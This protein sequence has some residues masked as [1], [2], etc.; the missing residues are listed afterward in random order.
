VKGVNANT[1]SDNNDMG[2]DGN[3]NGF[4]EDAFGYSLHYNKNDYKAI[5][6]SSSEQFLSAVASGAQAADIYN[7][8][9]SKMA[10]ALHNMPNLTKTYQYD[11]LNRLVASNTFENGT[12]TDKY[13]TSYSYDANGNILNLNRN[14]DDRGIMDNL[15]YHYAKDGNGNFINNRLL[16]VND[17]QTNKSIYGEDIDDQEID[18]IA[19][20]QGNPYSQ[21]YAYDKIGNLIADKQEEIAEIKWNV[22]GKVT[23]IIRKAGSDKADLR[24]AY[25][26]TGNRI[27]KT[28]IYPNSIESVKELTTYYVRDFSGNTMAVYDKKTYDNANEELLLAEQHLYGSSRLGM[29]KMNVLLASNNTTVSNHDFSTASK[30]YELTNHLGNVLAVVSDEKNT[31][32]TA[33]VVAAYDYFPFGMQMP[34]RTYKPDDYRYGFQNQEKDNEIS[35]GAG[36]HLSFKYRIYDSRI[37]RFLS[38]DPIA[39]SYPWNSSYA[40]SE[41]RVIDSKELEGLERYH[42]TYDLVGGNYE[43]VPVLT[44][45]IYQEGIMGAIAYSFGADYKESHLL[46]YDGH[47]YEFSSKQEM[48][49]FDP[50]NPGDKMD[51]VPLFKAIETLEKVN[52]ALEALVDARSASKSGGG[53]AP[54]PS[55]K[56]PTNRTVQKQNVAKSRIVTNQKTTTA[57]KTSPTSTKAMTSVSNVQ[58]WTVGDPINN[59]TFKGNT[60]SWS[61]VRARYWKNRAYHAEKGEFSAGNLTRMQKGLAPQRVNPTTGKT[62]SMELH[63][64]PPQRE[65]GLFDVQE[66]WPSEHQQVDPYRKTGQ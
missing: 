45:H 15:T 6:G 3:S 17:S 31:D 12:Q 35:G 25:D 18:G 10:T 24:F 54:K 38:V 39:N 46:H 37:G 61:T 1:L 40:F 7:G 22:Q 66:K 33:N 16:H 14:G 62:E 21:N 29:R 2:N 8:N 32:G 27:S 58:G 57:V 23:D 30:N 47:M 19:Y 20:S 65:G 60:P 36:S 51:L 4:S 44:E 59:K 63:H 49:D 56:I 13:K 28:V 11:E 64:D 53:K 50:E 41:N 34:N 55:L 43:L 48:T 26:G 52:M 9:I 42:Y 5:G